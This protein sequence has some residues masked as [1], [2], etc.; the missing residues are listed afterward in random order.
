MSMV[1]RENFDLS[2]KGA[3]CFC[4]EVKGRPFCIITSHF[5]SGQEKINRCRDDFHSM[6]RE[7]FFDKL[8][9]SCIPANKHDYC[10]LK[11]DLNL[12]MWMEMQRKD[13]ERV[14]RLGSAVQSTVSFA[15]E[16]SGSKPIIPTPVNSCYFFFECTSSSSS[17]RRIAS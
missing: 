11:R 17:L 4:F 10:F 6:M 12:D 5:S 9:Q 14:I 3:I 1:K 8:S 13:I 7:S 2:N 16:Q 15:I